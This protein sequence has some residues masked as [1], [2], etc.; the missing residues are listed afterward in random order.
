MSRALG[1]VEIESDAA[2]DAALA[3]VTVERRL[4]AKFAESLRRSRRYGPTFSGGTAESSQPGHMSG[5]PGTQAVAPR[6]FSRTFHTFSLPRGRRRTSSSADSSFFDELHAV[7][8]LGVAVLFAVAAELDE[9][10]A[11]AL[12]QQFQVGAAMSP[13]R[14]DHSKSR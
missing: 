8:G 7:P 2:V 6:P 10:K 4:I 9:Q 11:F 1:R 13:D 12:G 14:L 5:G 3:Q